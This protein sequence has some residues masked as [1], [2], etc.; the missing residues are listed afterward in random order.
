MTDVRIPLT[1]T[2]SKK[3]TGRKVLNA[4]N[5]VRMRRDQLQAMRNRV[6]KLVQ[7]K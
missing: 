4:K 1:I 5:E 3:V 7:E 6:K 2:R